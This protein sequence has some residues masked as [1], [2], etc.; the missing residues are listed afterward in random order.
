M[1]SRYLDPKIDLAFKRVFGEHKDLLKSFLNALLPLPE[2][3]PIESLTYLTPEQVP[4]LPGLFKNSI[5]DVKCVDTQGRTFIV[6]MQ[7]LWSASFAQRIVFAASQ[8]Y[9][10][11]LHKGQSYSD[12]QPVYA[13]AITNQI[14]DHLTDAYYH[15]YQIVNVQNP[16]QVLKGLEFVFIELPKFKPSPQLPSTTAKRMQVKWLRFLN[17]VGW[18][19]QSLSAEFAD[20][21]DIQTALGLLEMTGLTED[22]LEAYHIHMDKLRIEPTVLKDAETKGRAE[23]RAE[24]KAEGKAEAITQMVKALHASGMP[25][26][27]IS[28]ITQLSANEVSDFLSR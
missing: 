19:D 21:A 16:Q 22:E 15:H 5:V 12:L 27:K 9:V 8:A 10:K 11:Q 4:E 20:D 23:G 13:L 28:Q 7:M 1:P 18:N 3:A 25:A 2:D 26:E 17:E 14:F 6:E 24:G